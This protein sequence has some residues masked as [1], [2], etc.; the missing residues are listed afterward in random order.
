VSEGG[1]SLHFDCVSL[2]ERM[3]QNSGS[4]DNL[5]LRIFV[6]TVTNEQILGGKGIRLHIN[7]GLRHIVDE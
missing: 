7:V 4:V 1:D 6:V 2:I 5:P 3:V